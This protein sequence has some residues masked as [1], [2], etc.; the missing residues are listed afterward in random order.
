MIRIEQRQDRLRIEAEGQGIEIAIQ[1]MVPADGGGDPGTAWSGPQIRRSDGREEWIFHAQG[2]RWA[3]KRLIATVHDDAV[4]LALEVDGSG[5]IDRVVF[6]A[7]LPAESADATMRMLPWSRRPEERCWTASPLDHRVVA[8]PQP[9][10]WEQQELPAHLDQRITAATT[11]GP[12]L[13][14]T[15]LAPCLPCYVLDGS[16]SVGIATGIA[17]QRFTHVD[18]R[19]GTGWAVELAYDGR[20]RVE[21]TWRSPAIRIAACRDAEDGWRGFA[22]ALRRLGLAPAP[23]PTPAWTLRPMACTWGQQTVWAHQAKDGLAPLAGSPVTPDANGFASEAYCARFVRML[24]DAGLDWGT[25]TID[26]GWSTCLSIPEPDPRAWSDL[27]GFIAALHRR[28]KR[29]LLWLATWNPGGLDPALRV[30]HDDGRPDATDPSLPAFRSRL[31]AAITACLSPAGLDADGFKVDFT[32]DLPRGPGYR[33][34]GGSWGAAWTHDYLRLIW[35]T[36]RS[37]KADAVVQTHCASPYFGDVT[38][39]IR[40]ND[41]FFART[42]VRSGMA[43]RARIAR[44]AL[45]GVGCDTD[46]DPFVSASTWL[47][48]MRFQPDIGIPSIYSLTH[49]SGRLPGRPL[50]PIPPSALAEVAG[51]WRRYTAGL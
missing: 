31:T 50:D 19:A 17:E 9:N 5:S 35:E 18:Y 32:G 6:G 20:T 48:Y 26:A 44:T 10:S 3:A 1:G 40:L 38:N 2:G 14:N 51:I 39:C 49:V 29:V 33:P 8:N 46:N 41:L 16:W 36:A 12:A 37:A 22:G 11:F 25:L 30:A 43:F 7:G 42:D 21:G 34:H 15:F 24:D 27:K 45:P 23:Q 28:G 13:Y 47:D 4:L